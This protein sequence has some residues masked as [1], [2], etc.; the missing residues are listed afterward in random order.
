MMQA[1]G[2]KPQTIALFS[3]SLL[4]QIIQVGTYPILISQFLS[5]GSV[6][7]F[8]IGIF[9]SVA[10]IVVFAA[11]PFVPRLLASVGTGRANTIAF[12]F[13]LIS[14]LLLVLSSAPGIILVSSVAMGLGLIIRWIVCDTLVVHVSE[15]NIRGRMIGLHEA[16]MG[17]GI[18]LGPLLFVGWQLETVTWIC[19]GI[20]IAGQL[21]FLN[22]VSGPGVEE[23]ATDAK[24]QAQQRFLIQVILTA[25]VAAFFA[26]FIENSAIALL[27]LYFENVQFSLNTSAILVSSFGFGGTLLQPGL[28]YIA[29]RWSYYLAQMICIASIILSCVA[30]FLFT[31]LMVVSLIALFFLGGAA[32]GL[33]TLAVIEAGRSQSAR[34]IPAAMTAIAMLYTLGGIAGPVASGATLDLFQNQ[35]MMLLFTA[36]GVVLAV[37]LFLYRYR[38]SLRRGSGRR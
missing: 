23:E 31:D 21:A 2:T 1:R 19:I 36:S 26:G 10:W 34:Q 25:L 13:T 7:N 20:A 28:G 9:V 22:T 16:L 27:P 18:G 3:G 32:G 30:I 11:G 38:I 8:A 24:P 12:G 17:L 15:P 35:G 14:L 5:R 37:F 29:D 6:S 4:F 33:N